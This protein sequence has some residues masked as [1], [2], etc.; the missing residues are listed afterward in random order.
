MT[1]EETDIIKKL[2]ETASYFRAYSTSLKKEIKNKDVELGKLL[3]R[4]EELEDQKKLVK[5][6]LAA[7]RK[8]AFVQNLQSQ[9]KQLK[10]DNENLI[11]KLNAKNNNT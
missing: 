2:Q 10:K 11:C 1:E 7:Y 4:I 3:S 9:N 5:G 6:D 8:E